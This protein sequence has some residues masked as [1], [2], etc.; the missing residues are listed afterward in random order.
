MGMAAHRDGAQ[1]TAP[2]YGVFHAHRRVPEEPNAPV[3]RVRIRL[4]FPEVEARTTGSIPQRR[5]VG[6]E[7][8]RAA[9]AL[10]ARQR[11]GPAHRQ[12]DRVRLRPRRCTARRFAGARWQGIRLRLPA[13][14]DRLGASAVR[15]RHRQ[16][17]RCEPGAREIGLRVLSGIE[18]VGIVLARRPPP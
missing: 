18:G 16:G 8:A 12:A 15:E 2:F 17:A 1:G 5:E 11:N 9:S 10:A 7:C 4:M 6:P 3:S 13:A 14:T